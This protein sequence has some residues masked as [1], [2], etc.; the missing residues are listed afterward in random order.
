MNKIVFRPINGILLLDKPQGYTS[1]GVLQR[2][3]KLLRAEKGGHT[4]SLDPLATGLLPLCFGEAC[5][6]AGFLL[7]NR[8]A[9]E[10][11]AQLGQTTSTDDAEGKP[12]LERPVPSLD[13]HHIERLL[14][15]YIGRIQ[16]IPPVYSALKRDGEP[17]YL[18]ARRGEEVAVTAREVEVYSIELLAIEGT[19][20]RLRIVCGSGTYIR[21]LVRDLGEDLGCGGHVS[22]LRRLWVEPFRNPQMISLEA[23][24]SMSEAERDALILPVSAGLTDWPTVHLNETESKRFAMGQ[25]LEA[26]GKPDGLLLAVDYQGTPLAIAQIKDG[27]MGIKRRFNLSPNMPEGL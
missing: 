11:A 27:V 9:Y 1:N 14:K 8:K 21:S 23:L 6:I 7:G 15:P 19:V 12:M 5:K 26:T 4:G 10:V 17:L 16:Q 20:L 13:S 2:V 18:K 24:E 3:R 25:R 22:Q